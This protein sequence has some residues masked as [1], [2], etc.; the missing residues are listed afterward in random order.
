MTKVT[1]KRKHLT[2]CLLTGSKNEGMT[3]MME[4][5]VAGRQAWCWRR[6]EELTS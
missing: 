3:I 5:M 4:S 2:R 6:G 1:Y